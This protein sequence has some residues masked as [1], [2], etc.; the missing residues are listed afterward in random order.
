MTIVEANREEFSKRQRILAG[1][2]NV[3]TAYGFQR[4]TMD[5]IA[6]ECG[7][8]RPALY[9]EFKNKPDIFRAIGQQALE[10]SMMEAEKAL[11]GDG[12]LADRLVAAIDGAVLSVVKR[13]EATPHGAELVNLKHSIAADILASWHERLSGMI[14]KAISREVALSGLADDGI[15][16]QSLAEFMLDGLEGLKTRSADYQD[17][18]GGVRQLATIVVRAIRPG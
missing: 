14:S 10:S 15:D 4:T 11:A 8:S 16:P 1:A 18:L 3:F 13:Y 6:R 2:M 17:R 7:I 9:L 5:D 12:P